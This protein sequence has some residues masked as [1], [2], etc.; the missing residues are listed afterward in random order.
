MS[1]TY[2]SDPTQLPRERRPR[3]LS[4]GQLRASSHVRGEDIGRHRLR[5]RWL[6]W[7]RRGRRGHGPGL[8]RPA[9]LCRICVQWRTENL[10]VL[11]WRGWT[12]R[13][14]T[15][16]RPANQLPARRGHGH[17]VRP[18]APGRSL[19]HQRP[20][21]DPLRGQRPAAGRTG[22]AAG[23][24][25]TMNLDRSATLAPAGKSHA[26]QGGRATPPSPAPRRSG[27]LCRAAR[28][29]AWRPLPGPVRSWR[30]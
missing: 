4:H 17:W 9:E 26:G 12:L 13:G 6:A 16:R 18:A 19:R 29:A 2:R 21:R 15:R 3:G 25:G 27:H 22:R 7:S 5:G 24:R 23:T 20:H 1:T 11:V 28:K 30:G 14:G 10:S 8:T